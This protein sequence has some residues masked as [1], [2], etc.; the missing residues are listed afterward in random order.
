MR[1]SQ[2][3]VAAC[4][5]VKTVIRGLLQTC[6]AMAW[7]LKSDNVRPR[8][9]CPKGR[10][11]SN[12][13][14]SCHVSMPFPTFWK[15]GRGLMSQDNFSR[16]PPPPPLLSSS[17]LGGHKGPSLHSE[18]EGEGAPGSECKLQQSL[19]SL[20]LSPPLLINKGHAHTHTHTPINERA[21][22][23]RALCLLL[24]VL[25]IAATVAFWTM[26]SACCN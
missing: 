20:P 25:R 26:L 23:Y 15:G 1:L 3:K 12:K 5:S 13:I 8:S 7:I 21:T 11:D 2:T 16:P 19:V 24:R 14:H 22:T 10:S 4:D 6:T 9:S 17:Q 18:K